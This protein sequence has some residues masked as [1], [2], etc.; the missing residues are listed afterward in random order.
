MELQAQIYRE[1]SLGIVF[2]LFRWEGVAQKASSSLYLE[3]LT[4]E[5][6]YSRMDQKKF[7]ED[8]F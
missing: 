2:T 4:Y 8:S 7:V 1:S 5:T 6:K 3:P